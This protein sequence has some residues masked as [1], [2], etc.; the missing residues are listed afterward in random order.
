MKDL[1]II[2]RLEE[3]NHLK[4]IRSEKDRRKIV[5]ELTKETEQLEQNYNPVSNE[6]NEL[7]YKGFTSKEIDQY[8][9]YLE[10]VL[11]NLQSYNYK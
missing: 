7:L 11:Q 9:K 2:K 4:R 3:A 1:K 10:R 5:I 8:E 6:M